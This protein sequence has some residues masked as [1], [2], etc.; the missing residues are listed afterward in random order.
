MSGSAKDLPL[1]HRLI[2][3]NV[4]LVVCVCGGA[5]PASPCLIFLFHSALHLPFLPPVHPPHPLSFSL[6]LSH[7]LHSTHLRCSQQGLASK[8]VPFHIWW[9]HHHWVAWPRDVSFIEVTVNRI[10]PNLRVVQDPLWVS[11]SIH[12]PHQQT[13]GSTIASLGQEPEYTHT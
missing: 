13:Y 1:R 3:H 7:S 11:R 2:H 9:W 5:C 10:L 6:S 8:V 4:L 12:S